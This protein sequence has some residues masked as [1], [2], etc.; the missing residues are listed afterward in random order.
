MPRNM[1]T[2]NV[3]EGELEAM[4]HGYKNGFIRPEEYNNICQCE[5][6]GDFK[7]QMQ[8]TDYGNFLSSEAGL[9]ARLIS[10]KATEKLVA[11]FSELRE[12]ADAPLSTFLDF[13]TYDHML[14]NVLKLIAA[15]RSGNE[16]LELLRKCHP[17]GIFPGLNT[18]T[19][20]SGIDDMFE[21]V[22]IDSPIGRFFVNSQQ[23][24]F[25]ELSLEY[26]RAMLQRNY[27]EA[28]Y[29]FCLEVGG[30]TARVMCPILEFEA[31]RT[32]ITTTANTIGMPDIHQ[33]DRRKLFPNL[34]VLVDIQDDLALVEDEDQL[35]DRLKRFP[36]YAELF[37]DTRGMDGTTNKSLERKFVERS[38][39]MYKDAMTRQFQ[40]GVFYAWI[41]L[42]E[43]EISNIQWIADCITQSMKSRVHEY[44][45]IN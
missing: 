23:K 34:G 5:S 16:S 4:V 32:V 24:D 40:Y 29:D 39:A 14:N 7:S 12:W 31:D 8:V 10:E 6:L 33:S 38:V 36:E 20:A 17:L 22:L 2:Y 26:I 11:E 15:K 30:E 41:K 43:I 19:A 44:V 1:L 21:T 18:L 9:S 3:H 28:F 37:E 42:K 13:I 35:K 25:D 45:S 27:I